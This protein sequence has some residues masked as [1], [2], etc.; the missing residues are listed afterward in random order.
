MK[1]SI[2]FLP[3]ILFSTLL[4]PDKGCADGS[5]TNIKLGGEISSYRY[6]E[7]GL[8][9]HTG[10]LLGVNFQWFWVGT[11]DFKGVIDSS[12]V[13]GQ[14]QYDG[15]LCN[16]QTSVCQD[17]SAKTNDFI[18][19]VTHRFEYQF[20]P[21]IAGFAGPGLRFLYDKGE[22]PGFYT[23][24]GVYLFA[25]VGFRLE[26]PTGENLF[27]ADFEYDIFL[28]GTMNSKFSEVNSSYGD[29]T[30]KQTSGAGQKIT[31]GASLTKWL[32]KPVTVSL[33]YENWNIA[34]TNFE[35][36]YQDG[37]ATN[38]AFQEPKN[39]SESYGLK[40]AFAL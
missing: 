36:F 7:P 20:S 2:L 25:P 30:H 37:V 26:L 6:V 13:F 14:L 31:L 12:A 19:R 24:T 29:I 28:G 3:I 40:V 27:F 15:K 35:P 5:S 18:V 17:Y 23:R 33:Y 4:F 34:E 10:F 16:V 38:K 11:S 32:S 1:L 21:F 9:S 39:F 8:I 22:D